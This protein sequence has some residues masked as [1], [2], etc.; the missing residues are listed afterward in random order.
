MRLCGGGA[1]GRKKSRAMEREER[2]RLEA[3]ECGVQT[4]WKVETGI[5]K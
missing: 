4:I 2:E 3:S 5:I 1:V